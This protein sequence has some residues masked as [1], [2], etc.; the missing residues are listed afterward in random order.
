MGI[1]NDEVNMLI[2]QKRELIRVQD[3]S[4]AGEEKEKYSIQLKELDSKIRE[5][6]QKTIE[7]EVKKRNEVEAKIKMSEETI[8][9]VAQQVAS[10]ET[11][12]KGRQPKKDSYTMVIIRGLKDETITDFDKLAEYVERE[13]PGREKVKTLKQAKTIV[14]LIKKQKGG[15]WNNYSFDEEK[16]LVTE[17]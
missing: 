5:L 6:N 10:E 2:K 17:K 1:I 11:K 14:Y 12:K 7:E 8:Q 4:E 9:P 16:F 15:R 13:K 3:K